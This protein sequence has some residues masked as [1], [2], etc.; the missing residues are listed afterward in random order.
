MPNLSFLFH[1]SAIILVV[2]VTSSQLSL[3]KRSQG[4]TVARQHSNAIYRK[5]KTAGSGEELSENIII[6]VFLITVI[7]ITVFLIASG[8]YGNI[9]NK[10]EWFML[11]QTK[12]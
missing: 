5:K 1:N 4:V 9:L 11:L 12:E 7:L 10:N 3:G 6:T 2:M 8:H